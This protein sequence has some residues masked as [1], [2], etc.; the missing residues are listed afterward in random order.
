MLRC[1]EGDLRKAITFLQSAAR[2]VGAQGQQGKK[3]EDEM[4][5]DQDGAAPGNVVTVKS[6]EEIAGV[7][8]E[9][10]MTQLVAAM[11]PKTKGAV[12]ERVAAV[13]EDMVMDGWSAT[14]I[15]AQLYE[16]IVMDDRIADR[17]KNRI[18]LAFSEADKRLIDGSDEH[19]TVLDLSL[20]VAGALSS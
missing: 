20:K 2:L 1:A 17:Q 5:V 10:A 18:V 11:D 6:V 19:L 15:V 16:K 4:D 8:P 9:P 3:G 14:Q 13:V 12:Y 7:I